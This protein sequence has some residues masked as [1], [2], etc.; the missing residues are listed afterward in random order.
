VITVGSPGAGASLGFATSGRVTGFD[1]ATG[2]ATTLR[3]GCEGS[4]ADAALTTATPAT[5]AA[6][7]MAAPPAT[8][9]MTIPRLMAF[10][11][12]YSVRTFAPS[13][14]KPVGEQGKFRAR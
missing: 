13:M 12:L 9:V 6:A 7:R 5:V 8:A 2:S 1:C 4:V 14:R 11:L 10:S 3:V